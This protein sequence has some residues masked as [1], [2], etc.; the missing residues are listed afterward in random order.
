M[1]P[2]ANISAFSNMFA[3]NGAITLNNILP[4]E[5]ASGIEKEF[6]DMDWVVQVK[7]YSQTKRFEVPLKDIPNKD[8]LV[9]LLY[10][11]KHDI[12]LDNLFY[13]RLAVDPGEFHSENMLRAVE[14]LNSEDFIGKC[15]QIVG[16]SDIGRVWLEAT[17]YSKGCFLGNHRD[18][19]HPDN[20][21]AFV[22]NLT[23]HWK[24]DWG[25]L[26]LLEAVPNSPPIIVPP[27]WN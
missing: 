6:F 25:G 1:S 27:V 15:Q 24:L 3:Q 10:S 22:L 18:D 16:I 13:I 2:Q 11:V 12:D 23:R 26:L 21:V 19:H 5:L 20:R 14:F 8:N 9:G 4:E 17:C 7:D